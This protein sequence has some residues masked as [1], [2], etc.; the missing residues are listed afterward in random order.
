M[1]SGASGRFSHAIPI[2]GLVRNYP[3]SS[4]GV[5][6][7][8]GISV[9]V[10]MIPSVIAYAEL[11]GLPPAHGLYAALAAMVG[12]AV[13]ASS[14]QVIAGPDVAI[15]L[16]VA[17]AVGPL[18]AG[19]PARAAVLAAVTALLGGS[20]LLIAARLQ[21]GVIADF[22]S[23][24]V[25]IGYLTGAAL[26]L[27]STQLGKLF[28]I[29]TAEE[30]F[31]P[32]IAEVLRR[33]REAHP[34]TLGLGAALIA[35]LAILRRF[36]PRVPGP[37]VVS[38]I[39]LL[40]SVL[41]GLSSKGVRVIGEM[42]VGL[43]AFRVPVVSLHDVRQLLPAALGIALLTFPQGILLARAF[44]AKN[45]YEVRASQELAALA[46]AN[47][48]AGLFQGFSVSASQS[49][50]A[51]CDSVGGR[52]QVVSLVA[53]SVLAL[54]LLFLTPLLRELP[55]VAL[56]AIL[57]FAGW[58]LIE[59][60]EYRTLLRMSPLGFALAIIVAVGVLIVGVV[61]GIVLG[62]MITLVYLL[63]R[64][65]RP[66]DAVL[67]EVPGTGRYHDVGEATEARTT[68]GL[69]AYRFYAP[70]FFANAEHFVHRVREL[71]QASPTPVRW[72]LLDVQAVWEI[73]VTAAEALSRL[74]TELQQQ[75]ISL[76]IARANR[77]LREKLER[78]GL[79]DQLDSASYYPSVHA[80]VEAFQ[81]E[82]AATPGVADQNAP[83]G[84]VAIVTKPVERR[85]DKSQSEKSHER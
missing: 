59:L 36:V 76:R 6:A 19:D 57:I 26:I 50:T 82:H 10:I 79:A 30:D 17:S 33:I 53:G 13:F 71:I 2:L 58:H 78:I 24:P 35:T 23:K 16:L 28:G 81:R 66:L 7:L 11:A 63:A 68:P 83:D 29:K 48:A 55:T 25:L 12:Y 34:L 80:A 45:G 3:A 41:F 4:L 52:S 67:A 73:D 61:P 47:I 38:V 77:P 39:A 14:R 15:T 42:P 64:L 75:G 65:A 70:L 21:A 8:A 51:V 60:R 37:L 1:A 56:A 18:A 69:I 43:P 72:F 54:F 5:D 44:A 32:L 31:F 74:A 85:D 20:L 46:A 49:R 9:C 62:V 40:V 22:L 84:A 27:V